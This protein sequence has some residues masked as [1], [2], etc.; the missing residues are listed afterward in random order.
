M[1]SLQL[2]SYWII[3]FPQLQGSP[4]GQ[5]V[6]VLELVEVSHGRVAAESETA[7]FASQ[8]QG[9]KA[10]VACMYEICLDWARVTDIKPSINFSFSRILFS[11]RE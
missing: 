3:H 11:R 7:P 10:R 5:Q 4:H 8:E 2:H 1:P 6:Q 9:D